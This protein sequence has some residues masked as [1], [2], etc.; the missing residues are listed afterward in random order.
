MV[1]KLSSEEPKTLF[2]WSQKK[3]LCK[4]NSGE[5]IDLTFYNLYCAFQSICCK[6]NKVIESN[7][8][9]SRIFIDT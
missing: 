4:K 6:I 7:G 1:K 2:A 9:H 8:Y 3:K 5:D